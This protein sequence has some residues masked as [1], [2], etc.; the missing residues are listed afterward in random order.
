MFA[1]DEYTG[2]LAPMKHGGYVA[3]LRQ[4]FIR[5]DDGLPHHHGADEEV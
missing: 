5:A 1:R 3:G 4:D 2:F